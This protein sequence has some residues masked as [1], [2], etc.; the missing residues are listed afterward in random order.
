MKN[1]PKMPKSMSNVTFTMGLD[2]APVLDVPELIE[3]DAAPVAVPVII[4]VLILLDIVLM[5]LVDV[6]LVPFMAMA[7]N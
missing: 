4:L 3:V 7:W 6:A 5:L 1:A 2:P